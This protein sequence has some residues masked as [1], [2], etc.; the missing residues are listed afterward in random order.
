M[1]SY[2][3][4]RK[5]A[6]VRITTPQLTSAAAATLIAIAMPVGAQTGSLSE[7]KVEATADSYKPT[8]S[9]SPKFTQPLLDTPQTITVIK[10]E[11]LQDQGAA[12][13]TEALRNTPGITFQM[14]E[15]GNTSTGD[16]VFLRGFDTAGSIFVDG[17]RDV[18][19]ISRD[20]FNIE[21]IEVVKGPSGSDIGRGAPTGY[22]NLSSKV[23]TSDNAFGGTLSFGTD[24]QKRTTADI[25]RKLNDSGS[26]AFRLNLM[27]QDSGVPG[28]DDV[29]SKRW[30][31]AP[32]LAL[33][34][35]T[36]TRTYLSYLHLEQKDRPDGGIP[37]IG[38][39][40]FYLAQLAPIG[41]NGPKV[42]TSNYY[43]QMSDRDNVDADMFTA[44]VEHDLAP[45]VTLRNITRWGRTSQDLTVTGVFGN[46]LITPSL[47]NPSAWLMR[48]SPQG[49]LQRNEIIAN[50][51]NLTADLN[52][53]GL[54]HSISAGVEFSREEQTNRTLAAQLNASNATLVSGAYQAYANLYNPDSN[55]AFIPVTPTGASTSGKV[56]SA[57]LY[58][59]D[60]I[61]LNEQWLVN[62]GL[63]YEHYRTDFSSLAAPVGG[64][65][66]GTALSGN[67]N[68]LTGK[69]GVVYKP[70][71]N[72]SIY[73]AY[74]TSAKPPGSDFALAGVTTTSG[75]TSTTVNNPNVDPQKAKTV[76]VGTKWDV[77]DNRL[78]LSAALFKTTNENEQV[79]VDAFG[80]T[81]SYGKTRVKGA[82]LSA[83]GQIT[84]AWQLIA[85]LASIDTEIVQGARTSTTQN[86]AQVRYSPKLTATLWTTYKL[87]M[88]L[89]IGGGARYVDTQARSTTNV[90][91]T[92]TS[93]FPEI[94]S[95]TVFD[96]LLGYEINKNVSIQLNIYNLTDKFYLARVNNGGNRLVL[97]TP[98]S[99]LL[100]ANFKF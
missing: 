34:L 36:P 27:A 78:S 98:R 2:I 59:F 77:L 92:G 46:T 9:S 68:L 65:Q 25:N 47:A 53:G 35:G 48:V 74:A 5:H 37:T 49:K 81:E 6:A 86:G 82:E 71:S 62:A 42:D 85:G 89:T 18:G 31:V 44:R 97:G 75:V 15:N 72:G 79:Q 76:E 51:T 3:K 61:T 87:P 4:S 26:A 38:L 24:S 29:K 8:T 69:V 54:K 41:G 83:I 14:G 43:G 32:S 66:A 30:G 64:T 70:A 20:V 96:A 40:G 99:A 95:Y 93:F 50:Q 90:G 16:A 80:G 45:G 73:A 22:I 23:P 12:T 28:R 91:A 84:P 33:G 100:T 13:L 60:T 21:Q 56:T 58:A 19:S 57:A 10:K 11:V 7:V 94:P 88:G 1:A 63:R 52:L 55:R 17:I 67:D 39:S